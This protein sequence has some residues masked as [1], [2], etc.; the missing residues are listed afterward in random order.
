MWSLDSSP[1]MDLKCL[2]MSLMYELQKAT[3]SGFPMPSTIAP[4]TPYTR[5]CMRNPLWVGLNPRCIEQRTTVP[6][7]V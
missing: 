2:N 5:M 3:S 7:L 6:A 1:S 4:I